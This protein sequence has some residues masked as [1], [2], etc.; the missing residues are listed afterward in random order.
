MEQRWHT[1]W[2]VNIDITL[3]SI[4]A[5]AARCLATNLSKNGLFLEAEPQ[6]ILTGAAVE[7]EFQTAQEVNIDHHRFP[8]VVIH[9]TDSGAGLMFYPL[10]TQNLAAIESLLLKNKLEPSLSE[11]N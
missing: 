3:H 11:N 6:K 8:A 1:R 7:I 4:N 5:P 10:S 9:Y 2:P